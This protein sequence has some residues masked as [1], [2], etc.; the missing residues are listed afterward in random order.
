MQHYKNY[1]VYT[2]AVC[3]NGA[4]RGKTIVLNA[5]AKVTRQL[6]RIET[7]PDFLFLSKQEAEE[8]AF[9]LSKHW[10]DTRE[11]S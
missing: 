5:S 8:F 1:H 10:I 6:K 11:Q 9:R 7:V 3:T 4:W 2:G